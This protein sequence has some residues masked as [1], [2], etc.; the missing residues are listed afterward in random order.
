M[1]KHLIWAAAAL[2]LIAPPARADLSFN[3]TVDT[4]GLAGDASLTGP[5][6]VD[7]QLLQGDALVTNTA[8]ITHINLGTG[9]AV[10]SPN[11][12]SSTGNLTTGV[13]LDD[14]NF[15]SDFNQQFT[16]GSQLSFTVD[17]T[18][19]VGSAPDEFSFALLQNYGT[20]NVAEIPTTDPSGS[21]SLL[22]VN[23]SS[24]APPILTYAGTNGDPPTVQVKTVPEPTTLALLSLGMGGSAAYSALRRRRLRRVS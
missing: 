10:G 3:V 15:F 9:A 20:A 22:T 4:S 21:N 8:S 11:L 16:P 7:F 18:T 19:N 1:I 5:L 23:I 17:L 6:G 2:A 12:S 24:N 14:S 13:G